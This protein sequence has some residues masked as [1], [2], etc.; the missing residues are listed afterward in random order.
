LDRD[1]GT[2]TGVIEIEFIDFIWENKKFDSLESLK[3]Q[4]KQDIETVRY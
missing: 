1:I 2:V 4:I 3:E